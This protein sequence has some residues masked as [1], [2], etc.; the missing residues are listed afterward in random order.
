M[1]IILPKIVFWYCFHKC[2]FLPMSTSLLFW[3]VQL[4]NTIFFQIVHKYHSCSYEDFIFKIYFF[5]YIFIFCRACFAIYGIEAS[6]SPLLVSCLG[7]GLLRPVIHLQPGW[8][9]VNSWDLHSGPLSAVRSVLA[10][11]GE[12]WMMLVSSTISASVSLCEWGEEEGGAGA[13]G[14]RREPGP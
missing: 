14:C 9:D 3:P 6:P 5:K 8:G 12:G 10:F 4:T 13:K 11:K 1:V 7:A 2:L